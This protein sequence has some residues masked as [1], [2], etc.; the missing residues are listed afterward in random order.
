MIKK[1]FLKLIFFYQNYLS[2]ITTKV[3][4]GGAKNVCRFSPTCSEYTYQA[5]EKYGILLGSWMGFKRILRCHPW[6][7]GGDDPLR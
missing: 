1:L 3:F 6:S 5:I 4:F 2:P 7:Q